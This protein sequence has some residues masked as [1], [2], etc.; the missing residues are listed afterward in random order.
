[1]Y[2]APLYYYKKEKHF[3]INLF[4][5]FTITFPLYPEPIIV[6]HINKLKLETCELVNAL[7]TK[8]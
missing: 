5:V 7:S 3:I 6:R 1:M 8:L 2:I 4:G